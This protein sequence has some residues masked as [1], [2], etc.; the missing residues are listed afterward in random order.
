MPPS[1]RSGQ[2]PTINEEGPAFRGGRTDLE[3][4]GRSSVRHALANHRSSKLQSPGRDLSRRDLR[5]VRLISITPSLNQ[6]RSNLSFRTTCKP[7][8][9]EG[10]QGR[11]ISKKFA[12]RVFSP[13]PHDSRPQTPPREQQAFAQNFSSRLSLRGNSR[14]ATHKQKRPRPPRQVARTSKAWAEPSVRHALADRRS[15]K[16]QPPGRDLPLPVRRAGRPVGAVPA[17]SDQWKMYPSS[18]CCVTS[19]P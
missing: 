17:S 12:R 13:L 8:A 7:R 5:R 16:L 9:L 18:P 14:E 6:P 15:S 2:A 4:L 11:I 19:S 1:G 10:Q 3:R